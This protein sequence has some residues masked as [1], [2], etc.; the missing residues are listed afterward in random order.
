MD[1]NKNDYETIWFVIKHLVIIILIAT[2][3]S[4]VIE[5]V[6]SHLLPDN[7]EVEIADMINGVVTALA[8]VFVIYE[9]RRGEDINKRENSIKEAEF[10]LKYNQSFVQD[11]NMTMVE[12]LLEEQTF[13][14]REEEIIDADNN[15]KFINYLV[16]LE[17][18]APLILNGILKLDTVDDLMAYRF[19][20]SVNNKEVQEKQ[21]CEFVE[22][23]MG[24]FKLY[25]V[26]SEYRLK[27]GQSIVQKEY[28]S[29]DVGI[30]QS[31]LNETPSYQNMIDNVEFFQLANDSVLG[32][33]HYKS[34]AK[35]IYDTDP[36]IYPAMFGEGDEGRRTAVK[37]LSLLLRK[38]TDPM[39]C[40]DNIFIKMKRNKIVG[41]ILWNKGELSWDY[42]VLMSAAQ[43]AGVVL[44]KKRLDIVKENYFS[45]N[46]DSSVCERISLINVCVD[47]KQRGEGVGNSLL[48]EFITRHDG[49]MELVVLSDNSEA[50]K[51]Y[52]KYGFVISNEKNG[53]SLTDNKPGCYEMIR[54]VN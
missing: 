18:F 4:I 15:Q 30:R 38:G 49:D 43:E 24:C 54:K 46:Y 40:L 5:F 17:G 9:L 22:Y 53:F 8:T 13:Y 11:E 27:T 51:L 36:F 20:L 45:D 44:D 31:R 37:V 6:L 21:L 2:V 48:K 14:G 28:D 47:N 25:K 41:L 26:W 32:E 23:Y 29:D 34:I 12:S 50:V 3:I 10:L 42:G 19:F 7:Y 52:Q 16:Y 35:L 1:K 33:S 39:F